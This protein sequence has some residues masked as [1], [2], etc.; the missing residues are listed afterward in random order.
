[1]TAYFIVRAKV[2][3]AAVKDDLDHWYQG[4]HLPDTLK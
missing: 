4:E 1:M 2:V 3:D